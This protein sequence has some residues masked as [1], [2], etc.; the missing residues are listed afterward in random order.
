[1]A[2]SS[3]IQV[4]PVKLI[5][6]G[7]KTLEESENEGRLPEPTPKRSPRGR[8]AHIATP[9]DIRWPLV[10]EF[11]RSSRLSSN[12]QKLYER[13]LKRFLG[14]T[15]C[16]W[17]ELQS[18]HLGLYKAYLMELEIITGKK[19]SKNSLNSAL[20]ALKSFFR[21]LCQFHPE[22]CPKN[23]TEGVKFERVPLPPAQNLTPEEM[24]RVWSA[25]AQRTETKLRDFALVQLLSHNLRAGEVAS[26]NVGSFDGRLVTLRETKN[27]QPRIVPLSEAG[28]QAIQSYLDW[29]RSQGEALAPERPLILSHHQ[30]WEGERLSYHGIYFA[31]ERI[32]ELA[33][34][35]ELHPHQFR[36]T[37]AT[38]LLRMGMDPAHARL[39]T[40]HTDERSFRRYTLAVEQEA[41]IK[42]FYRAKGEGQ[43][44]SVVYAKALDRKQR[45]LLIAMAELTQMQPLFQDDLDKGEITFSELWQE[46]VVHLE[47]MVADVWE[48]PKK[49]GVMV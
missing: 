31:V 28:Q 18:R 7:F 10:Q 36:H 34:L 26:A 22:L 4:P 40:G 14:W 42:A 35:P 5:S 24:E 13:E 30:G 12:S 39:L 20:T 33:G 23:P 9:S 17:F 29:R 2:W 44:E 48:L 21:W 45:Q 41:A 1:M 49:L 32:G 38:E 15:Q 25:V 6:V 47:R 8:S 43:S 16:R 11:L 37:G 19:L 3:D 46:N 27:K